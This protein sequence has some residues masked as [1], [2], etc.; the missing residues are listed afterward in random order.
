MA[1]PWDDMLKRMFAAHP[2]Q[3]LNWLLPGAVILHELS[4]ELKTQTLSELKANQAPDTRDLY[5][6]IL[7]AILWYGVETI[8]HI[9]FQR[10]GEKE[11]E[12]REETLRETLINFLRAR[13]PTLVDL[14]KVQLGQLKDVD[15]L[16]QVVNKMFYLQTAS[17]IEEALLAIRDDSRNN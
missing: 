7:Y 13:Y 14:A 3:F 15:T 1:K 6:D 4:S 9:E 16:Q 2:Q 10:R 12:G 8:V 17:E 5:S 11:K